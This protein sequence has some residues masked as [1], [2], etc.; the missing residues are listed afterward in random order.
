MSGRTRQYHCPPFHL[1]VLIIMASHDLSVVWFGEAI[2]PSV[3]ERSVA[4]TTCDLFLTIV[5]SSVVYPTSALVH[6]AKQ[7][8]AYTVEI[9]LESTPASNVVD[10]A[11]KGRSEQILDQLDRTVSTLSSE[12]VR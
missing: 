1:I 6:E 2:D 12:S 9:N 8:G 11:L 3:V 5:T 7:Q 4:A 10:L